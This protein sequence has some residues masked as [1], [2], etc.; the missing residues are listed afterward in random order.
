MYG[1]WGRTRLEPNLRQFVVAPNHTQGYTVGMQWR[2]GDSTG[3]LRVQGELT[4]LE[5]SATFRDVP[6]G[7]WYTSER[8]IQGYTNR[9]Q[10]LGASIGPGSSGQWLAIDYLKSEWRLGTFLGRARLNQDVHNHYP[11]PSYVAY[12]N[13]D[14]SVYSGLR[15][16]RTGG[17]GLITAELS[18]QN[19]RTPFFQN[20]GG[21]PNNGDRLDLRNTTISV[22]FVPFRR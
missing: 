5:Q 2:G 15:G 10:S 3:G 22:T 18:T 8:V 16:A 19:R 13:M 20:G 12:C 21:C 6:L 4:Q 1:E 9:G 11:F 7:S 14:V 17:F